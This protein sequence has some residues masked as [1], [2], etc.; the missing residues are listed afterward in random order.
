MIRRSE[1]AASGRGCRTKECCLGH[2]CLITADQWGTKTR[3]VRCQRDQLGP[4]GVLVSK[5]VVAASHP[6][7]HRANATKLAQVRLLVNDTGSGKGVD[8]RILFGGGSAHERVADP[9]W[10]INICQYL[11]LYFNFNFRISHSLTQVLTYPP[12]HVLNNNY[13]CQTP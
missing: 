1:T 7:L 3:M 2:K 8:P 9:E 11:P 6:F 4:C 5:P 12:L 13:R 10:P